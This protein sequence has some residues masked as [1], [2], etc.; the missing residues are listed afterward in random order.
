MSNDPYDYGAAEWKVCDICGYRRSPA[1][2]V[3]LNLRTGPA[4]VCADSWCDDVRAISKT[5]LSSQK[6]HPQRGKF[7]SGVP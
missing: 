4:W 2:I 7:E 6:V 1:N 5:G 3:A